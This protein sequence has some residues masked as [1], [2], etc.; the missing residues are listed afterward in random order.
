MVFGVEI[1]SL[2]NDTRR[3]G[4]S[5]HASGRLLPIDIKSCLTPDGLIL[6]ITQGEICPLPHLGAALVDFPLQS[7][8]PQFLPQQRR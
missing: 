6:V 1:E 2:P 5:F 8:T 4:S 7:I 3:T